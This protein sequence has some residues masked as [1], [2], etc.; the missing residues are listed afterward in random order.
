MKSF[1]AGVQGGCLIRRHPTAAGHR[2]REWIAAA[3]RG[4][5]YISVK[6]DRRERRQP[7]QQLPVVQH[8]ALGHRATA[9]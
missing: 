8:R 5:K 2:C 1:A 9:E 7:I 4:S 3:A 6:Y